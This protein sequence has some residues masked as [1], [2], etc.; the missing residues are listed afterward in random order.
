MDWILWRKLW[1]RSPN[2]CVVIRPTFCSLTSSRRCCFVRWASDFISCAV[3]NLLSSFLLVGL[4]FEDCQV[5]GPIWGIELPC[6]DCWLLRRSRAKR[7]AWIGE[8]GPNFESSYL[9]VFGRDGTNGWWSR[10][11]GYS[12]SNGRWRDGDPFSL[13]RRSSWERESVSRCGW[14]SSLLLSRWLLLRLTCSY[15]PFCPFS[16]FVFPVLRVKRCA[17]A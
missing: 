13:S 6:C 1:R 2:D 4:R 11:S 8:L 9:V 5:Y 15:I 16:A 10:G 3:Y 12:G 17:F 14:C 7:L